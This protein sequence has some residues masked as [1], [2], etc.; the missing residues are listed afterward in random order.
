M[1]VASGFDTGFS[2]FYT[3]TSFA[4]DVTVWSGLNGTGTLLTT[5]NLAA[6]G[7]CSTAPNFCNWAAAGGSFAG[8]A[9][10]A[11][12]TGVANQIGFDN[13][14][15]G[16]SSPGTVPEPRLIIL[17]LMLLFGIVYS[18]RKKLGFSV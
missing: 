18:F 1:D 14:T 15:I 9:E 7:G 4:G 13:I 5:I 16:S 2:F 3:S 10:S 8:V 17:P 12:F 6:L 11:I